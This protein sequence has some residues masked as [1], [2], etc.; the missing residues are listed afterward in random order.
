MRYSIRATLL[1][2]LPSIV[3]NIERFCFTPMATS[4]SVS[5]SRIRLQRF[6]CS[7]L[8]CKPRKYQ[9]VQVSGQNF[10]L[11]AG[12]TPGDGTTM[13][14]WQCFD[15]VPAQ[16]WFYTDDRRISLRDRGQCLDLTNGQTWN[17]NFM[18]IWRCGN[19]N[20][21]QVWTP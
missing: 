2:L 7:E 20:A 21:N 9:G 5:T 13:K 15:N 6:W 18:Q 10:C 19:G 12:A 3:V 1:T 8:G 4:E 14:I 11:D 17:G 16:N